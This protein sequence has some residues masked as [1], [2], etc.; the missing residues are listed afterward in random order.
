MRCSQ[1][2]GRR[3]PRDSRRV[4]LP[5]QAY[6]WDELVK[7]EFDAALRAGCED[8]GVRISPEQSDACAEYARLLVEWNERMNLTGITAPEEMAI[9]HFVDSVSVLAHDLIPKKGRVVDVG[10][11]AGFPGLCLRIFRPD[12]ELILM[13]AVAKRLRFLEAVIDRLQL[14][15]VV[16]VHARAEDAG[17]GEWRERCDVGVARAVATTNVLAEYVLPLVRIGGRMVAWKGPDVGQELQQATEASRQ[18][19]GGEWASIRLSLPRGHG[20]R[21]LVWTDKVRATPKQ[22]PRKPG[23][24]KRR[25]LGG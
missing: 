10:T 2:W 19:G 3:A 13:D 25:P 24:P 17:R 5:I 9:K 4:I 22:Y 15:G 6:R 8:V 20:Q 7:A 14:D 16:C 12:I 21:T 1:P 18:L 11:G 23:E